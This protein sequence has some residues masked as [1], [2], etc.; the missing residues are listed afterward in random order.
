MRVT[1]NPT[2]TIHPNNKYAIY[3]SEFDIMLFGFLCVI[4]CDFTSGLHYCVHKMGSR[5]PVT[6]IHTPLQT[7]PHMYMYAMYA[8]YP[9]ISSVQLVSSEAA[10][11]SSFRITSADCL[12]AVYFDRFIHY[13]SRP[14][15]TFTDVNSVFSTGMTIVA[16]RHFPT[17]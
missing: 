15:T 12:T 1:S 17:N 14:S 4:I 8:G 10:S 6:L 2:I 9:G 3:K 7:S 16:W 5:L 13:I 11:C